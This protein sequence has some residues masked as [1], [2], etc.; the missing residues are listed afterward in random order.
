VALEVIGQTAAAGTELQQSPAGRSQAGKKVG[1]LVL[2]LR[3]W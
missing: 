1:R 3:G 2:I